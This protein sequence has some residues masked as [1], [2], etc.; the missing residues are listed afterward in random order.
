MLYKFSEWAKEQRKNIVNPLINTHQKPNDLVYF[1][2]HD[3]FNFYKENGYLPDLSINQIQNKI[4][5]I[6]DI[7]NINQSAKVITNKEPYKLGYRKLETTKDKES[8]RR[9]MHKTGI[10]HVEL[11]IPVNYLQDVS[12]LVNEPL[13]DKKLWL[14]IDGKN[15]FQQ[16]LIKEIRKKEAEKE[17]QLS[18]EKEFVPEQD[19]EKE[20]VPD[21]NAPDYVMANRN[22]LPNPGKEMDLAIDLEESNEY[23]NLWKYHRDGRKYKYYN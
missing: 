10:N 16:N 8:R 20:F 7:D 22:I 6:N 11:N 21:P 13:G 23:C 9:M 4:G 17:F 5:T 15:N 3:L 19:I 12:S 14:V 1:G 2:V 18:N